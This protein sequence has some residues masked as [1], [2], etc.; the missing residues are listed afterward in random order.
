MRNITVSVSRPQSKYHSETRCG[1]G[2]HCGTDKIYP[3]QKDINKKVSK[4][5]ICLECETAAE[6]CDCE[7][8]QICDECEE[9]DDNCDCICDDCDEQ[10]NECECNYEID[11]DLCD[12]CDCECESAEYSDGNNKHPCAECDCVCENDDSEDI[13]ICL[14]CESESCICE[15]E[16]GS[17]SPVIKAIAAAVSAGTAAG[18]NNARNRSAK[19]QQGSPEYNNQRKA[20]ANKI[21]KYLSEVT[22]NQIKNILNKSNNNNTKKLCTALLIEIDEFKKEYNPKRS[23]MDKLSGGN[24]TSGRGVE[25]FI[26][27]TNKMQT[28]A[29]QIE[30]NLMD[31][32]LKQNISDFKV[33]LLDLQSAMKTYHKQ[34]GEIITKNQ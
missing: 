2:C 20:A 31:A 22:D 30:Q 29:S 25:S 27:D 16:S 14:N 3:D 9:P 6:E 21:K 12:E 32:S 5:Q 24:R 8:E 33:S 7:I 4:S 28:L 26:K 23:L 15:T 1:R 11:G 10:L 18:A 34:Y 13:D 19:P 17:M